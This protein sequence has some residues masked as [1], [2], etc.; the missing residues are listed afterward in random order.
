MTQLIKLVYVV[1]S[2]HLFVMKKR[3]INEWIRKIQKKKKFCY[4]SHKFIKGQKR[5]VMKEK[6][7]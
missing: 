4:S 3:K 7:I 2:C 6:K 1:L 5:E